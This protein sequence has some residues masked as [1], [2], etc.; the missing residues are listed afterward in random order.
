[1]ALSYKDLVF[2]PSKVDKELKKDVDIYQAMEDKFHDYNIELFLLPDE[3]N[4]QCNDVL[5]FVISPLNSKFV[6]FPMSRSFDLFFSVTSITNAE[7]VLKLTLCYADGLGIIKEVKFKE[8]LWV[9]LYLYPCI[10]VEYDDEANV[11]VK[12][13]MIYS[14]GLLKHKYKNTLKF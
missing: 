6:Y 10:K 1:M 11:P 3:V 13:Q 2:Q 12:V 9:P 4:L 7:H 14:A 5:M 8:D